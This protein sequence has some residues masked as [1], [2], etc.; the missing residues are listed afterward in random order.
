MF[1][2]SSGKILQFS[3]SFK[4]KQFD[5]FAFLTLKT[6]FR[7]KHLIKFFKDFE[8]LN[9]KQNY[10]K[11]KFFWSTNFSRL[12]Q[13]FGKVQSLHMGIFSRALGDRVFFYP[14]PTDPRRK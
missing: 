13:F 6:N 7:L 14:F 5:F 11:V 2:K 12:A 10:K 1:E 3:V 4:M 9:K 8:N